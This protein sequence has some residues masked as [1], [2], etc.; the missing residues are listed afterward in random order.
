MSRGQSL[1]D[2]FHEYDFL[3]MISGEKDEKNKLKMIAMHHIQEG[4]TYASAAKLVNKTEC[5]VFRWMK[6]FKQSGIASLTSPSNKNKKFSEH[7]EQWLKT[8]LE[9][10]KKDKQTLTLGQI[11]KM[12]AAEHGISCALSTIYKAIYRIKEQ[13]EP[14]IWR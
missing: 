11:Q 1:P 3:E 6:D 7:V 2:A 9:Q 14:A 10:A 4:N 12:L 5:T 8:T 13:E